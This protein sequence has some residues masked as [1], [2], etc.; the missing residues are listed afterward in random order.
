MVFGVAALA[1]ARRG[2]AA[3]GL[4]VEEVGAFLAIDLS[5]CIV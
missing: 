3:F 4:A 1:E 2:A 5:P